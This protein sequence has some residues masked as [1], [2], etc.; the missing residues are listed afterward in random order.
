MQFEGAMLWGMHV[1]LLTSDLCVSACLS[2]IRSIICAHT[3]SRP[4]GAKP[5][6][7]FLIGRKSWN[8]LISVDYVYVLSSLVL[9]FTFSAKRHTFFNHLYRLNLLPAKVCISSLQLI[10][11]TASM[12]ASKTVLASPAIQASFKSTELNNDRWADHPCADSKGTGQTHSSWNTLQQGKTYEELLT[13]TQIV[14]QLWFSVS[15]TLKSPFL[16]VTYFF[17][18]KFSNVLDWLF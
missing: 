18:S 6:E 14:Q 1:C 7:G 4:C 12:P 5:K 13:G 3:S 10:C 9:L 8:S 16:N 11:N 15:V 2:S 17:Y